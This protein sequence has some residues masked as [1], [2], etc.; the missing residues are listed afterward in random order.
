[1]ILVYERRER[2]AIDDGLHSL[3]EKMVV[4]DEGG[5]SEETRLKASKPAQVVRAS[6]NATHRIKCFLLSLILLLKPQKLK[7]RD[8]PVALN[9]IPN[10]HSLR[11]RRHVFAPNPAQICEPI[12]QKW[13]PQLGSRAFS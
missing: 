6:E 10:I 5:R 11:R 12:H 7:I 9:I 3:E 4:G 13:K 2:L 1:M 8:A